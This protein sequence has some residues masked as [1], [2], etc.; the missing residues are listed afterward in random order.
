MHMGETLEEHLTGIM[1]QQLALA[2]TSA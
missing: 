2:K 1:K